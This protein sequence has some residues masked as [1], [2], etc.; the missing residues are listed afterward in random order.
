MNS[1]K[2][3]FLFFFG[4]ILLLPFVCAAQYQFSGRVDTEHQEGSIY[5]SVVDDYRKISGVYP[6]QILKK[7]KADSTGYF[8][9]NGN[10]LPTENRIYRIHIDLCSEDTQNTEHFTGHCLRSKEIVF[11]AN[12]NTTIELPFSFANEMFCSVVSENEKA[13]TFLKIDSLKNDMKFAF[14]T[15]RSEANKKLNTKKWFSIFQQ[16]GEQLQEPLAELYSYTF[17]SDRSNNLHAYYLED[18]KTNAY[19]DDLLARLKAKY[20]ESNYVKQYESELN[21]DRYL[22]ASL[23]EDQLPWWVYL[24]SAVAVISLFGNYYFF[25]KVKNLENRAASKASL[26]AQEQKVLDLILQDKSNKEIADT[27]FVSTSTVKTHIN[28]LYKKLQVT[29]RAEVKALYA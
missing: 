13:H 19:Y 15:Y 12:N 14:G 29:S 25:G 7:T 24:A 2:T 4:I 1:L 18:L 6:E 26:S 17:F 5:L 21:A 23:P 10:N 8:S 22:I 11:V 27:L 3:P 28:N 20:P 9:F 16:Y